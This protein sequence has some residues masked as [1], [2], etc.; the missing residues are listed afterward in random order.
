MDKDLALKQLRAEIE[1][2]EATLEDKKKQATAIVGERRELVVS[3]VR[4]AIKAYRIAVRELGLVKD[5][6]RG[7]PATLA[8]KVAM[9]AKY[10]GPHGELWSGG[11][12]RKPQWVAAVL[13]IG[14]SME[15]F[16]I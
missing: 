3:E 11:R 8:T 10:R 6:K 1:A 2:L 9:A 14:K 15:D 16:L 5:A 4:E 12:G 7:R 13:A